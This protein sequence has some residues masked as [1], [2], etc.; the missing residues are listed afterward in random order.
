ML[1]FSLHVLYI[2]IYVTFYSHM[3]ISAL[4]EVLSLLLLSYF[5]LLYLSII[6]P[7]EIITLSSNLP[8]S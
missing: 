2:L 7:A 6:F 4:L 8:E 5:S 1:L 3:S